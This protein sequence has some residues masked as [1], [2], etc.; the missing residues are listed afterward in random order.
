MRS[1]IKIA[2]PLIIAIAHQEPPS[3]PLSE[4]D[5]KYAEIKLKYDVI[6]AEYNDHALS[7]AEP[8]PKAQLK[9]MEVVKDQITDLMEELGCLKWD[10]SH[11]CSWLYYQ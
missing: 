5:L 11:V 2:V 9:Q 8:H 10:V 1:I 7:T 6:I 3:N 4:F